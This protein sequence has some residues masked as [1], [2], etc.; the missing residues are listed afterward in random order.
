MANK[1][2]CEETNILPAPTKGEQ[3]E[4]KIELAT[5]SRLHLP[6]LC[7]E[8]IRSWRSTLR[9]LGKRY[10]AIH[11][12]DVDYEIAVPLAA[13]RQ[14]LAAI[15]ARNRLLDW[16]FVPISFGCAIWIRADILLQ[17]SLL[18][19][20]YRASEVKVVTSMTRHEVRYAL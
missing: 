7:C 3:T 18:S 17:I 6:A 5:P 9:Q 4:G 14:E 20:L 19:L 8:H 15:C 1:N 2:I 12:D 11:G 13:L 16:C 10:R